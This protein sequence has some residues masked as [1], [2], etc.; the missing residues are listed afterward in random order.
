MP[1]KRWCQEDND[2]N[3]DNNNSDD[4][5]EGESERWYRN[6]A[7]VIDYE[8]NDGELAHAVNMKEDLQGLLVLPWKKQ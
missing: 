4:E 1:W 8:E 5:H 7:G 3:N 2:D 6:I